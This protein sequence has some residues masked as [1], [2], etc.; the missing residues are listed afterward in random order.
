MTD[1]RY[2]RLISFGLLSILADTHCIKI[3]FSR[4]RASK[5]LQQSLIK[6]KRVVKRLDVELL[7]G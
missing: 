6:A 7:F 1:I 3:P 2:S 5:D 4:G